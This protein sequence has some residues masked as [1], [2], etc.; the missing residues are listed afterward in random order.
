MCSKQ[1]RRFKYTCFN[2]IAG[3]NESKI[4]RKDIS[5]KCKCKFDRRKYNSNKK[6]NNHNVI[7]SAKNL[8]YAKKIIFGTLLHLVAKMVNI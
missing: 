6:W 5:C 3:K 2:M 4:L 1:N 8:I 7:V